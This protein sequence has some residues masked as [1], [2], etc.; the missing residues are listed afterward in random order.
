[1]RQRQVSAQS[2]GLPS[3][4]TGVS[5]QGQISSQPYNAVLGKFRVDASD[6]R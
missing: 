2:G 5:K 6:V 1:M 4:A 3:Q